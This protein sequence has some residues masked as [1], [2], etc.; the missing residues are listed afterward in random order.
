MNRLALAAACLAV[1]CSATPEPAPDALRPNIIFV[2]ADDLG[3]GDLS[4]YGQRRF[5]TPHL[6]A[7]AR[8]GLRFTQAYAGCT[9][10]APSRAALLTGQHTGHVWQRANGNIA[11][12]EDPQDPCIAAVLKAAGYRTAMIGKSGLSCSSTDGALPNRKGFDHFFGFISHWEAH[13]YYPQVLYRDGAKVE[14]AGNDG[15]EGDR[16]SG[17]LFLEDALEWITA[18]RDQPFFLHLSLQQPHADLNVPAAW[19][20][21][22][23]GT[24]PEPAS[25]EKPGQHYR[26]EP[27]PHATFA[28]MV[29]WLDDSVGR[30]VAHLAAAGL[31]ENTIVIFTSDNGAHHE[32]GHDPDFFDSTGG[33]RGHKRDM[34][35]GGLRVPFIARWPGRIAANTTSDVVTAFWDFVPTACDL[36]AAPMT[37]PTDGVS[38]VPTLL[39]RSGQR[40]RAYLYWEFHEQGGKQAVRIGRWKGVRL[41]A[42]RDPDGPIELYDLATDPHETRD[43]ANDHPEVVAR[44]ALAMAEAHVPT[45]LYS[46]RD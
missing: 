10:C 23:A 43:V 37:L 45:A 33:L 41:Q 13:R 29:S 5:E 40:E 32:G 4:C 26:Y 20:A 38:I 7:L 31:D 17:D 6:D 9:V 30:L 12:R 18:D 2:L 46:F 25:Q 19:R 44:I 16:Y 28:A 34:Y 8:E 11:F 3:W 24:F 27:A 15:K 21:R 36:A 22:F 39:G 35:E 42:Q 14:F 1:G